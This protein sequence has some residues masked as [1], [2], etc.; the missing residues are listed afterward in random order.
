MKRTL[1][2]L[3]IKLA[4]KM[5]DF[6]DRHPWLVRNVLRHVANAPVLRRYLW[7]GIKGFMGASAFDCHVID[8]QNGIVDFG[9]VKETFYPSCMT[10]IMRDTLV[11]MLGEKT[12]EEVIRRIAR[13]SVYM[14]VKFGVEGRWFPKQ[15]LS[16]IGNPA[17]LEE[18]RSNP[19]L[20]RLV[21]KGLNLTNRYI[22]D[23]GGYGRIESDLA[24]DPIRITITNS[25]SA[26]LA[27]RSERP[28]CAASCGMMEGAM[29]YMMGT[30]FR[31]E[32]IECAATGAPKC[33]FE[34]RRKG[35][36]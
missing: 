29:G 8:V 21:A 16:F 23:E 10:T 13:E 14:E 2:P 15:F 27:G 3:Q 12:A 31:A 18:M 35:T 17:A 7:V 25:L 9:G 36:S 5:T 19:D 28:V 20:L 22:H 4:L 6:L 30:D 11:R 26:R 1:S 32:E 33:V 24:A 34:L